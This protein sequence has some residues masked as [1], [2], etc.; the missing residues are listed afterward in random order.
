MSVIYGTETI[1]GVE[2]DHAYSDAGRYLVRDGQQFEEAYD[3]KGSGRTYEEGDPIPQEDTEASASEI[4]G[5][6]LGG[7]DD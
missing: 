4:L 5:I 6:L 2:Y 1:D 3:P 7:S